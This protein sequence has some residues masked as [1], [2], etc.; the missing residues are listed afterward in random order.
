MKNLIELLKG[1][2]I[3]VGSLVVVV[4]CL[5]FLFVVVSSGGESFREEVKKRTTKVKEISALE[6]TAF[7][8]PDT[9]P[10]AP[11]R[12]ANAAINAVT[13]RELD[14]IH[15]EMHGQYKNIFKEV[16][17]YNRTGNKSGVEGPNVHEPMFEGLFP[18][19]TADDLLYGGKIAYLDKL[20]AMLGPQS[21]NEPMPRINAGDRHL[22]EYEDEQ[23]QKLEDQFKDSRLVQ[24]VAKLSEADQKELWA[25]KRARLHEIITNVAA[26]IDVYATVDPEL[27]TYPLHV[28]QWA[29]NPKRPDLRELWEGQMNL[30]IQQDILRAIQRAND[31]GKESNPGP[32]NPNPLNTARNVITNPVKH[33][34]SI[35]VAPGYVGINSGGAMGTID[36][37]KGLR[38]RD[39]EGG[40]GVNFNDRRGNTPGQFNAFEQDR[41]LIR[42]QAAKELV[43]HFAAQSPDKPLKDD[44]KT[45]ATGRVSNTLYDVRHARL[46][47]IVD[48]RQ[49]PILMKELSQVNFMTVLNVRITDV[50]EYLALRN[51]YYYGDADAVELEILIETIWL[52]D[53]TK[54]LMPEVIRKMLVIEP[55]K[56]AGTTTP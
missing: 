49:I 56:A 20:K 4:A 36:N 19:A 32:D 15:Q 18:A 44:F 14:R 31:F 41:G 21:P 2:P 1:S 39:R 22:Q 16:A 6:S 8:Y 33:L 45:A 54:E 9:N 47:A 51:G 48:Y 34:R 13:L 17:N 29:K 30:W 55:E 5:A 7:L 50:D 25:R 46:I 37:F 27:D 52:R 3:V 43:D 38:G 28:G 10:D 11:Y 53:W 26:K 23:L 42:G 24:D 35:Q 40:G 12:S